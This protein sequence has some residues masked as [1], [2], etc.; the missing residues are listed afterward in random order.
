M[1]EGRNKA[2]NKNN[3]NLYIA[4]FPGAQNCGLHIFFLFNNEMDTT[5]YEVGCGYI[6]INVLL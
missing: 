3:N 1:N 4:L 2:I 6:D 5:R